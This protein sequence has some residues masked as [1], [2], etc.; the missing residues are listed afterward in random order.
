M[1]EPYRQAVETAALLQ[2]GLQS[3]LPVLLPG[4]RERHAV[5][6]EQFVVIADPA[7]ASARAEAVFD[8]IRREREPVNDPAAQRK[9][10]TVLAKI[11][12][13]VYRGPDV[14]HAAVVK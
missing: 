9:I 6:A 1:R 10:R 13:R 3:G 4:D 7:A 11:W 12:R 14:T 2:Q 8:R 5:P